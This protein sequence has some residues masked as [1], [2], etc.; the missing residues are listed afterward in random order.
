MFLHLQSL[1]KKEIRHIWHNHTN[2][3]GMT[4]DY[5]RSKVI[6]FVMIFSDYRQHLVAGF[7]LKRLPL[8]FRICE[9]VVTE[10]PAISA[11]SLIV[12]FIAPLPTS[13]FA[14]TDIC[15]RVTVFKILIESFTF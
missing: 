1:L 3:F 5:I 9:T 12:S 11:I 13:P 8:L 6:W 2:G 15:R 14:L 4:V 10:T 7:S